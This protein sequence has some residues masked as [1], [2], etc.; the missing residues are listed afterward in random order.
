MKNFPPSTV[1]HWFLEIHCLGLKSICS[2]CPNIWRTGIVL[3]QTSILE[4]NRY[5]SSE[6]FLK[7]IYIKLQ[8]K[9]CS[10][11]S[12]FHTDPLNNRPGMN[13]NLT[14]LLH[15]EECQWA[16]TGLSV[17]IA[18]RRSSVWVPGYL[19]LLIICFILLTKPNWKVPLLSWDIS[20]PM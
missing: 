12:I 3:S 16:R 18:V 4:F 1:F 11:Y 15:R 5:H 10:F 2:V 7:I 6:F 8:F 19:R 17:G 20:F 9:A 13:L 14:M